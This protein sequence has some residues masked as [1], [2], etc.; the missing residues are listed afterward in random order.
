[1]CD[2]LRQLQSF[3]AE[4]PQAKLLF[5]R[6][7]R[8]EI[9]AHARKIKQL[10]TELAIEKSN[11]VLRSKR[12][13]ALQNRKD[14][15]ARDLLDL[16]NRCSVLTQKLPAA[17]LKVAEAAR[18]LEQFRKEASDQQSIQAQLAIECATLQTGLAQLHAACEETFRTVRQHEL[19]TTS[20]D[21]MPLDTG[22][23]PFSTQATGGLSSLTIGT[24]G[25]R[26]RV[27]ATPSADANVSSR[28]HPAFP[29][30]PLPPPAPQR[31]KT[32]GVS[33]QGS[34]RYRSLHL[35]DTN[36]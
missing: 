36:K 8:D 2:A 4:L 28:E 7:I 26:G 24:T 10:E 25:V 32:G 34:I 19:Q 13:S 23:I 16:N 6:S 35:A 17:A 18:T 11:I 33:T 5:A 14:L 21:S 12:K 15:F 3:G 1:M 30:L 9:E 27:H 20:M 31:R 22:S 29:E